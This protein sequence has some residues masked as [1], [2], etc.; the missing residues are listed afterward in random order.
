LPHDE[1]PTPVLIST[2]VIGSGTGA[3]ET[4]TSLTAEGSKPTSGSRAAVGG[5]DAR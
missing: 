2:S 4:V 5:L 3:I 1:R